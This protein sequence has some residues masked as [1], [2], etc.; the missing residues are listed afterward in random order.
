MDSLSKDQNNEESSS[1]ANY[2]D[3]LEGKCADLQEQIFEMEVRV[4]MK[5]GPA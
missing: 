1:S 3:N 5:L 2:V 4:T